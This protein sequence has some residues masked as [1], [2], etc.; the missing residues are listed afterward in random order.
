MHL[1]KLNEKFFFEV[2]NLHQ[3][4][5]LNT[6]SNLKRRSLQKRIRYFENLETFQTREIC[7]KIFKDLIY[8]IDWVNALSAFLE[9]YEAAFRC[10]ANNL[11]RFL[12]K[13]TCSHCKPVRND[14]ASSF[15]QD[16][17]GSNRTAYNLILLKPAYS[18]S[19]SLSFAGLNSES[20]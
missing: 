3:V 7:L 4:S 12:Q 5:G 18:T 15:K 8:R 16:V 14:C 1:R 9:V 20:V 17:A 13:T 10:Y 2:L 19:Q 6:C 11:W